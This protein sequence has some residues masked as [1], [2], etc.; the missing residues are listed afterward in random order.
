LDTRAER[1]AGRVAQC[2]SC[3]SSKREGKQAV[4]SFLGHSQIADQDLN[5]RTVARSGSQQVRADLALVAQPAA[6][7]AGKVTAGGTVLM[8]CCRKWRWF[9]VCDNH[10]VDLLRDASG[11]QPPSRPG[12]FAF[13]AAES[14]AA[15]SLKGTTPT[16]L[17]VSPSPESGAL[18]SSATRALLAPSRSSSYET[19]SRIAGDGEA[20]SG[21]GTGET[22]PGLRDCS[23][24][25]VMDASEFCVAQR[26]LATLVL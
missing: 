24:E 9:A 22:F 13:Q 21:D 20:R 2:R 25:G 23:F 8:H 10:G 19:A 6:D 16:A 17:L 7:R 26:T 15:G 11:C 3:C 1:A 18:V 4:G 14:S 12:A 5:V